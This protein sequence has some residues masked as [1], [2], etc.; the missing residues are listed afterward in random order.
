[1]NQNI[2]LPYLSNYIYL[3]LDY[4]LATLSAVIFVDDDQLSF[5]A[6]NKCAD[7]TICCVTKSEQISE[8]IWI[9]RNKI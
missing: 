7:L 4:L 5:I 9:Y 2:S 6:K 1:M 8:K 3:L